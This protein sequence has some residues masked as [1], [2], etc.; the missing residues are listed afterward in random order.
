MRIVIRLRN[1]YLDNQKVE[2]SQLGSKKQKIIVIYQK[3]EGNVKRVEEIPL[4][5]YT[6]SRREKT[7][8]LSNSWKKK[9]I[10]YCKF[11][12]HY[13]LTYLPLNIERNQSY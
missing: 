12:C 13:G 6:E 3:T 11:I 5:S 9:L 4:E 7:I 10:F 8:K 2:K 1:S